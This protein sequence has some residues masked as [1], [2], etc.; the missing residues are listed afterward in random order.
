MRSKQPNS[1]SM[2]KG[3]SLLAS[4]A[5]LTASGAANAADLLM[6]PPIETPEVYTKPAGGWYLR[7][8]ISYETHSMDEIYYSVHDNGNKRFTKH[9]LDDSFSI[10]GGLGYQ[11]NENFRVDTTLGYKFHSNFDGMTT[12]ICPSLAD[13]TVFIDCSTNDTSSISSYT[14]MAN[15]YIDLGN[16]GG[17]TPYVGAGIGG[18]YLTWDKLNNSFDC[19]SGDI[20][21]N[22]DIH[23][24]NSE[25]RFAYALHAGISYDI[26]HALKVDFGYS[27]EH[28][29]GGAMFD[30]LPGAVTSADLFN[31]PQ[32]HD[33]GFSDHVFRAGIRYQIW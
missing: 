22:T 15:G 11:I 9:E 30:W 23:G 3:L 14:L 1:V 26:S 19:S 10:R 6:D 21:C 12:G 27:Y 18:A 16:F 24:G 33:T 32:G 17:F 2:R 31:G 7:G 29:S 13:P 25:W 28:I 8:D 20:A 4:V 5:M